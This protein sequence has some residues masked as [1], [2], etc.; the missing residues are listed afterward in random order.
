MEKHFNSS[1]A[2]NDLI[3]IAMLTKVGKNYLGRFVGWSEEGMTVRTQTA[4]EI[5]SVVKLETR[6]SLMVA[7]VSSSR[8]CAKEYSIALRLLERISKS[9]LERLT[10][11]MHRRGQVN[12]L[13]PELQY[14][15]LLFA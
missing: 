4:L 6:L 15:D 8:R 7:E 12:R 10:Q 11:E 1:I 9:D 14:E 3:A 2:R 13:S 5:G